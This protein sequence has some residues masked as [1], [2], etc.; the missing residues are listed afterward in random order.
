MNQGGS[1]G[2]TGRVVIFTVV[3]A[4]ALGAAYLAGFSAGRSGVALGTTGAT[5]VAALAPARPTE[6]EGVVGYKMRIGWRICGRQP[7][8]DCRIRWG[9]ENSLSRGTFSFDPTDIAPAVS[10]ET[11]GEDALG[12][13][14]DA[15]V[16][17]GEEAQRTSMARC[18]AR[19][20]VILR[21]TGTMHQV[22]PRDPQVR[23]GVLRVD[24][25]EGYQEFSFDDHL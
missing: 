11:Q 12:R 10:C 9:Y 23:P 2:Q 22:D 7:L 24:C 6:L 15:G 13:C 20:G 5:G 4:F 14:G 16:L 1:S 18:L 17:I 3:G 21:A 8:H 19:Y 25:R